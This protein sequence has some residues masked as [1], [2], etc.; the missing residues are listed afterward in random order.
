MDELKELNFNDVMG[1]RIEDTTIAIMEDAGLL[2][3][4]LELL[5]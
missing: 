4:N 3:Q 2:F 5:K 1:N